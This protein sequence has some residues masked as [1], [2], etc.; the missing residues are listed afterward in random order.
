MQY[1]IVSQLILI[2]QKND[3]FFILWAIP[4]PLSSFSILRKYHEDKNLGFQ[5]DT[6]GPNIISKFEPKPNLGALLLV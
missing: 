6:S 2:G 4:R 3:V 1:E 5:L